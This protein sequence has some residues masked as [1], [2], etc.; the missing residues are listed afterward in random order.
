[1]VKS[2]ISCCDN[3][4]VPAGVSSI[5]ELLNTNG[6]AINAPKNNTNQNVRR[7][8]PLD[9]ELFVCLLDSSVG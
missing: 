8:K 9:E 1:M 4:V 7:Q 6:I 5:N 3:G 2:V